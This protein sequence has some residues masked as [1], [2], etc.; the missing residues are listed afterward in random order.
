MWKI[1][2]IASKGDYLYAKVPDHPFCTRTGYVLMHR[3]IMENYLGRMLDK[4][5]VV[6]HVDGNKFNNKISNLELMTAK[7]H[8]KWHTTTGRMYVDC[9]CPW[10]G[11]KFSKE[12][13]NTFLVIPRKYNFCCCSSRCGSKLAHFIKHNGISAELQKKINN[14][15]IREYKKF[16]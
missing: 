5:E 1:K 15:I 9:I 2:N 13:R 16:I 4:D 6:H 14:C 10:C 12:R 3:V 11:T 8:V 7:A